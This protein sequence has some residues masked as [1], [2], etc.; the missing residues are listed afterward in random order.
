MNLVEKMLRIDKAKPTERETKQ[1]VSRR[2]SKLLGEETT[3]TIRELSGKRMNQLNSDL[4][5]KD[6]NRDLSRLYEVN[7]MYC[8]EGVVDPS[9]KDEKL[10]EHFGA[11]TPKDLAALLFGA[12]AGKIADAIVDLAGLGE[13]AEK[14]IKN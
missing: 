11:A 1:I 2:L 5:G 8:V 14:E 12:E 13:K 9:L 6:G 10:M 4:V 7:L 3:I